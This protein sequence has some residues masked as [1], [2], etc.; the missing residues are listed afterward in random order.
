MVRVVVPGDVRLGKVSGPTGPNLAP[1]VTIIIKVGGGRGVCEVEGS[2][3]H[4]Y[5]RIEFP[6]GPYM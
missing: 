3:H 2:N 1:K 4:D 5:S 6:Q